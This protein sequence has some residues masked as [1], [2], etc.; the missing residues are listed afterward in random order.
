MNRINRL[1]MERKKHIKNVIKIFFSIVFFTL[2]LRNALI[3]GIEP[4]YSFRDYNIQNISKPTGISLGTSVIN[5]SFTSKGTVLKKINLYYQGEA[6]AEDKFKISLFDKDGLELFEG[7]YQYADYETDIWNEIEVNVS[8]MSRDEEYVIRFEDGGANT[9]LIVSDLSADSDRVYGKCDINGKETEGFVSVGFQEVYRYITPGNAMFFAVRLLLII[10]FT[11]MGSYSILNIE[12]LYNVYCRGVEKKSVLYGFYFAL[13]LS[14]LFNPM[15]GSRTEV[16]TFTREMGAG[17]LEGYDAARTINNFIWWFLLFAVLFALYVLAANRLMGERKS[18][19]QKKTVAFLDGVIVLA[20]VNLFLRSLT[21]FY[22]E[23]QSDNVYYYSS[24]V[25]AEIIALCLIYI[26]FKMDRYIK[27]KEYYQLLLCAFTAAFPVAAVCKTEWES[28]KLLMGMQAAFTLVILAVIY[29][30]RN[31]L[32]RLEKIRFFDAAVIVASVFPFFTSF[33]FEFINVLN[34]HGL[35][36]GRP[37]RYYII[38]CILFACMGCVAWG[39]A[40]CKKWTLSWWKTWSYIWIITGFVCLDRQIPMVNIYNPDFFEPAN[41]GVLI[42]GFLRQGEIPIIENLGH[43]MTLDVWEGILYGIINGDYAGAIISP[44]NEMIM[45]P[46]TLLFY[47][48]IRKIWNEDI[49]LW[50]TLLFPFYNCWNKYAWGML[51]CLAVVAF[52]EKNTLVRSAL[53]WLSCVWCALSRADIGVAFGVSCLL[54]LII[55][56]LAERNWKAIRILLI[57]LV[58]IGSFF[59]CLWC[60]L[61]V[62]KEINPV[63]RLNE[64]IKLFA[65]SINWTGNGIGDNANTVYAFAYLLFPFG[66]IVCLMYTVFSKEF[67]KN[68]GLSRW[69]LLLMLGFAYF[70]NFSRALTR[71]S[72]QE[73]PT[74]RNTVFWTV[75]V[76]WAL[77]ISCLYHK[78]ALFIPAFTALILFNHMFA[79]TGNFS[80]EPI[81][82]SATAMVGDVTETWAPGR[83]VNE[84]YVSETY[85]ERLSGERRT[86]RRVKYLDEV[87]EE[88][89][90][91]YRYIFGTLLDEDD[92]FLDFTY[93]SYLYAEFNKSNPVYAAQSPTMLSGEL[94]QKY[95]IEEIEQNRDNIPIA[96]MPNNSGHHAD[97]DGIVLNYKYYKVAEFIYDNYRPLCDYKD[98]SVWCLKD[99]YDDMAGLLTGKSAG[100]LKV[101]N[102]VPSGGYIADWGYDSNL[103]NHSLKRLPLYWAELDE[104]KAALNEVITKA[105]LGEEA[106]YTFN[107][108]IP[109]DA[110]RGNYL[111]LNTLYTGHDM[112]GLMENDDEFATAVLIMGTYQND[113]FIETCRYEFSIREGMH[114]YLF[115]VSSDYYWGLGRV[116]AAKI[117]CSEKLKGTQISILQGD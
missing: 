73:M 35:F 66:V 88:K 89:L 37:R 56:I 50:T 91:P 53:L 84:D 59:G 34:Q 85:W 12:N 110:A 55:Y 97:M 41:Y 16:I 18:E 117:E 96:L 80:A 52:A 78:R 23:A 104:Q 94:S 45:V 9:F 90:A 28:G 8:G 47:F 26:V 42:N 111:L 115:R 106:L 43:H 113:N 57:P 68:I 99:R 51:V 32:W 29:V 33:Y 67:K 44:Y 39:I 40:S 54:T 36:V 70:G 103:H 81:A 69:I 112:N 17:L 7:E 76:F 5:Q 22:D 86:E 102:P 48:F 14:F 1:C 58:I 60:V 3:D 31:Q 92:T 101:G 93:N 46:L 13:Y 114:D 2:V 6:G 4:Y 98:F 20:N 62:V 49:A 15:D 82:D 116:N 24:I 65:A 21:F 19:E 30:L 87:E 107:E 79:T 83:F 11:L 71:H 38:A 74:A 95:F 10:I 63:T 109:Y 100:E 75:Y 77:F 108:A 25:L 72:L 27:A 64:F 105:T 61:C